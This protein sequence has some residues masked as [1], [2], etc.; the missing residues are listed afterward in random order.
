M[1]NQGPLGIHEIT[2]DHIRRGW[3][4]GCAVIYFW[5][6]AAGSLYAWRHPFLNWDMVAYMGVAESFSTSDSQRIYDATMADARQVYDPSTYHRLSHKDGLSN[7]ASH[8][9]QQLP[10]YSIKP[11]YTGGIWLLHIFGMPMAQAAWML[12]IIGFLGL[13]TL[14]YFFVP[15]GLD[16]GIWWLTVW[17]FSRF[18]PYPMPAMARLSTPDTLCIALCVAAYCMWVYR[19]SFI[20]FAACFLLAQLARPDTLL[21]S[22]VMSLFFTFCTGPSMRMTLRLG[23]GFVMVS[24]LLYIVINIITGNYG[25]KL[26]FYYTF[27]HRLSTPADIVPQFGFQQYIHVF[28]RGMVR[29][30]AN[31]RLQCMLVASWLVTV[32]CYAFSLK[33]QGVFIGIVWMAWLVFAVRFILFPAWGSDRYYYPYYF[34]ML[35]AMAE[36]M[37]PIKN[38]CRRLLRRCLNQS[39]ETLLPRS[40]AEL[41]SD[42]AP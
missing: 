24:A 23:V 2:R 30:L 5:F 10:L 39:H 20:G 33:R 32:C 42:N 9:Y 3:W 1:L 14:C 25:W 38:R 21:L 19:R 29:I 12:D 22:A 31:R 4:Y 7:S 41:A 36:V 18:G 37:A 27:I 17:L 40:S 35:F 16:A 34:I 28:H 26:L 13:G 11:L 15:R 6:F 8:F